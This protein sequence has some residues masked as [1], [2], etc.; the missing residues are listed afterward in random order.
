MISN[1]GEDYILSLSIFINNYK[2][3][4]MNCFSRNNIKLFLWQQIILEDF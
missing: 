1:Y 3:C 4:Q 2:K